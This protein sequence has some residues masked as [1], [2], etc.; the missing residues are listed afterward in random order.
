MKPGADMEHDPLLAAL[1]RAGADAAPPAHLDDA[2]RA[3]ARREV[4]AGPRRS[5][6]R[7]WAVPVSLAAVLVLSV[8]V[9]TMMREQGMDRP[10]SVLDP[11]PA[12]MTAERAAPPAPVVAEPE[13]QPRRQPAAPAMAPAAPVAP[14]APPASPAAS[15]GR[16]AEAE[17]AVPESRAKAAAAEPGSAQDAPARREYAAPQPLL[18]SA[19]P[20]ADAGVGASAAKP[21]APAALAAGPVKSVLWQDL[22]KEPP[23]KW[24]Q[25]IAE[26]RRAGQTADA[27]ALVAEFRRR[28]P[29]QRLPEDAR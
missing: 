12:A 18:R 7:R 16:A 29:D 10:E 25:R 13:V 22:L 19:P 23:E 17:Q 20:M 5:G 9:V 6:A 21:A 11:A 27:E 26:L 28:F 4:A 8:S 3:A 15:S 24:L 14:A 2:I 1:Y